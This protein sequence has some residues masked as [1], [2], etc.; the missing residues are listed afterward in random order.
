MSSHVEVIKKAIEFKNP[1][2]LPMEILD[3]P[4]IYNAYFTKDPESVVLIPGTENFDSIAV[5]GAAWFPKEVG[6]NQNGE[7]VRIDEFGVESTVPKEETSAYI[8]TNS[9]L[10]GKNS[11]SGYETPDPNWG[12]F[13]FEDLAKTI[14]ERY[15]D[16][17]L[18]VYIDPAAFLIAS[19]LMGT[20]YMYL[21][22]A[23][24]VKFV[25]DVIEMLFEYQK[26]LIPKFKK[27][28]AHMITY[29]D[30]FASNAGMMF[31]PD[32]W[33][34]YFK[35][36]YVDMF[37]SIH[38]AGLYTCLGLDGNFVEIIDDILEMEVDVL[39]LYDTRS[40]GVESGLP[41]GW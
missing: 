32:I 35:H 13:F 36:F 9:P 5:F 27:V 3:V 38:E 6:K 28:G 34:K 41:V 30:E 4:G 14:K 15:S 21:K 17:F 23:D 10:K 8:I 16:R 24:N 12:D 20:E 7:I 11:I 26:Q 19:F 37:K 2:Y 22:L 40:F 1:E 18:N 25:V 33:K 39:E 31:S 29:L